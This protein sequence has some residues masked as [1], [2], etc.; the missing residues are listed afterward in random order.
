V[1]DHTDSDDPVGHA[2]DVHDGDDDDDDDAVVAEDADVVHKGVEGDDPVAAVVDTP[3]NAPGGE[4]VVLGEEGA[5]Y[6]DL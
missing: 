3:D 4:E 5:D 6:S 2:S 1:A